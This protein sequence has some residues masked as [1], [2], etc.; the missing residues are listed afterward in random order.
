M[1][2]EQKTYLS[3]YYCYN[4]RLPIILLIIEWF[5]RQTTCARDVAHIPCLA[6]IEDMDFTDDLA[7]ISG[8]IADLQK[9][10]DK[11]FPEKPSLTSVLRIPR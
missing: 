11:P 7:K 5:Q 10:T 1:S 3:K 9:K 2:S 8:N 4:V 6:I